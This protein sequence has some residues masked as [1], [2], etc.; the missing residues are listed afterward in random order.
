MSKV[1]HSGDIITLS[2]NKAYAVF[3][4]IDVGEK[5]F[6]KTKELDMNSEEDL[7]K[8]THK[9]KI[10]RPFEYFEETFDGKDV[11]LNRIQDKAAIDKLETL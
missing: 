11:N 10:Q 1:I 8:I 6:I 2:N 5:T 9:E 3:K 7:V 4:V